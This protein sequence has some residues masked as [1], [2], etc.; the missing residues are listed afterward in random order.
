M[1]SSEQADRVRLLVPA[2]DDQ[3]LPVDGFA[4]TAYRVNAQAGPFMLADIPRQDE[5]DY[6]RPGQAKYV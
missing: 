5:F 2:V 3:L 1:L 4:A 6:Q